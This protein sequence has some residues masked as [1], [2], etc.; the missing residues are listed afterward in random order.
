MRCDEAGLD[1]LWTADHLFQIPVTGLPRES[2]MLEGYATIAFLAGQTRRIRL[3]VM[4]TSAVYRHPGMLV[5]AVTTLDVL[6]GG[7]IDFAVGAGWDDRGGDRARHPVPPDRRALRTP[8]GGA[9]DRPSDV[10]RRRRRRS[11]G[12]TTAW[13]DR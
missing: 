5:K 9:A 12:C 6:S 11:T 1:S 7:R 8:R 3:G 13:P 4:V 2:P 10:V